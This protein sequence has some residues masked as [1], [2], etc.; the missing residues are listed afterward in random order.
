MPGR[1]RGSAPTRLLLGPGID[2]GSPLSCLTGKTPFILPWVRE[3]PAS[4]RTSSGP[5]RGSCRKIGSA[6]NG[7]PCTTWK[8]LSTRSASSGPATGRPTGSISAGPRA[9]GRTTRRTG[10]TARAR[11]CGISPF[12]G[13]T[14]S[15]LWSSGMKRPQRLDLT[16]G[17]VVTRGPLSS[18]LTC[19]SLSATQPCRKHTT[20]P[21][22]NLS[23]H[24]ARVSH[25]LEVS[26]LQVDAER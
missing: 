24:T 7:T 22:V 26:R 13:F 11:R 19:A 2:P 3:L 14:L 16:L 25:S 15:S 4:P 12:Q 21:Y 20:D 6:S 17:L 8:P 1:P 23:A 9:G 18:R 10:R 5:W